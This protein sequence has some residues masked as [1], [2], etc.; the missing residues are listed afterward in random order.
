VHKW[1]PAL[2]GWLIIIIM[3]QGFGWY[4]M[5]LFVMLLVSGV[6][7]AFGMFFYFDPEEERKD[8][9]LAFMTLVPVSIICWIALLTLLA[10][11]HPEGEIEQGSWLLHLVAILSPNLA[12][13]LVWQFK[14]LKA[15]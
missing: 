9:F 14:T 4:I 3:S 10:K 13:F 2:T 12:A 11:V 8:P 5:I 7:S 1:L 6:C 15:S